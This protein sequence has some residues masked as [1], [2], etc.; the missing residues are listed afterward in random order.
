MLSLE[1]VPGQTELVLFSGETAW[2]AWE[3]G[4]GNAKGL[5]GFHTFVCAS[6]G[7]NLSSPSQELGNTA[8]EGVCGVDCIWRRIFRG[9][10]RDALDP[11]QA[12]G[13]VEIGMDLLFLIVR[14]EGPAL[15]A[16]AHLWLGSLGCLLGRAPMIAQGVVCPAHW[17]TL[18]CYGVSPA[19]C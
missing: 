13:Q 19:C 15:G 18:L 8:V 10:R 14:L 11:L 7:G 6:H 9:W 16:H 4:A 3:I 17:Q 5:M 12:S 1:H 2:R